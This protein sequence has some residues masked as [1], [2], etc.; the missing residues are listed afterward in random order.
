[1]YCVPLALSLATNPEDSV[2]GRF[3][4]DGNKPAEPLKPLRIRLPAASA[5]IS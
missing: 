2:A 3:T 1:M 4:V 5:A